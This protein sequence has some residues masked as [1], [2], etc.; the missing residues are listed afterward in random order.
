MSDWDDLCRELDAWA[1]AGQAAS[2]WWR[3]DDATRPT[4]ALAR[5]LA[6]AAAHDAPVAVAVIPATATVALAQRLNAA[7]NAR[8]RILQH[9]FAHRNHAPAHARKCELGDHRPVAT[10]AAELARGHMRMDDLFGAGAWLPV[11]VPPWNRI[12]PAV[13]AVLPELGFCGLSTCGPRPQEDA[14]SNPATPG[15]VHVNTHVDILRWTRPRGFVGVADALERLVAHLRARRAGSVDAAEPTGLL[16]HH[17]AHDAA[18]WTFLE[19]LIMLLTH[20]P[21]ARLIDPVAAFART[22]AAAPLR[23]HGTSGAT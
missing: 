16:T 7:G 18:A 4:P 19:R 8:I 21:G 9:G 1:D 3:D 22:A 11:L 20:H 5:L 13:V 12:A 2:L 10:V 15:L 14:A 6:I 23:Q 17:L